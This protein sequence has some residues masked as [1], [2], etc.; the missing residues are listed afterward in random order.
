MT[1]QGE[2]EPLKFPSFR[3]ELL[4][5]NHWNPGDDI[6]RIKIMISEGF[7]RDSSSNPIERVKNIVVFSFQH[8]PLGRSSH[9]SIWIKQGLLADSDLRPDILET[10]GIAWPNPQMWRGSQ[11]NPAMPVPTYYPDD[12]ADS[13]LHSP[14]HKSLL[15][16]ST[17]SSIVPMPNIS[18]TLTTQAAAA[19]GQSTCP[20]GLPSFQKTS[21]ASSSGYV[22]PFSEAAY[23]EWVN[24]LGL[25]QQQQ[26]HTADPKA[27]WPSAVTRSGNKQLANETI[28]PS[29]PDY[30]SSTIGHPICSNS[31]HFSGASL[32]DDGT[33]DSLKVP[34]NTPTTV[35]GGSLASSGLPTQLLRDICNA[36]DLLC[37]GHFNYDIPNP[38]ISSE[39]AGSLTHS[40]LNQP[41]PIGTTQVFQAHQIPLPASEVRSRKENRLLNNTSSIHS[42]SSNLSPS[43]DAQIRKFSQTSNA[44]GA[45]GSD[46]DSGSGPTYSRRTSAGDFGVNITNQATPNQTYAGIA[47]SGNVS[48]SGSEKGTKRGRTFTPASAKAIDEEDEPRRASPKMRIATMVSAGV[49]GQ[50]QSDE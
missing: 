22:D 12:G 4:Y 41:H 30:L 48:G 6:G 40:L 17:G 38:A 33:V 31:M 9:P 45:I 47:V 1:K 21:V 16:R 50:G 46:R 42:P 37:S 24:S 2:L 25:H 7:P 13:H 14:R 26:Q 49:E 10:N 11:N 44:F 8:A 35:P 3:R 36:D 32:D 19:F 34:T 28:M 23:Q 39:L 27:I 18:S 15:G 29:L 5:Q 20:Q 43:V